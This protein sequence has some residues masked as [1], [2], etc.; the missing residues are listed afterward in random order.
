MLPLICGNGSV[1][2]SS[3]VGIVIPSEGSKC[4]YALLRAC[5]NAALMNVISLVARKGLS[6]N[7]IHNTLPI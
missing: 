7:L 5:L 3:A 2:T 4:E 1:R 6:G